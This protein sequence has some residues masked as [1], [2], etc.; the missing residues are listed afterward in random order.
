MEH[1]KDEDLPEGLRT[2]DA[3]R[4]ATDDELDTLMGLCRGRPPEPAGC[5]A[6]YAYML[7]QRRPRR[8]KAAQG[9][10][11]LDVSVAP[12]PKGHLCGLCDSTD[13][14]THPEQ[15]CLGCGQKGL[16][17]NM[18][19]PVATHTCGWH[20]TTPDWERTEASGFL[21][22]YVA[23]GA[24]L[25]LGNAREPLS[26]LDPPAKALEDWLLSDHSQ[27]RSPPIMEAA[28]SILGRLA[29]LAEAHAKIAKARQGHHG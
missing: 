6:C 14:H 20:P 23:R 27:L 4:K 29:G 3:V 5:L 2:V 17:E 12:N 7:A 16:A 8:A 1:P 19:G 10:R 18:S 9:P 22:G 24:E 28:A 21:A 26:P 11:L 25:G 13:Q 15:R